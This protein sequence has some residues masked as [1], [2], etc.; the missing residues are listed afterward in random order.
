MFPPELGGEHEKLPR[1]TLAG[2]TLLHLCVE[3]EEMEI[4]TWL[5]DR[6][7]N[8][9]A[10]AAVDV[11]GFGG[12]TAL[13]GAVVS[14]SNTTGGSSPSIAMS[15]RWGGARCFRTSS[16]ECSRARHRA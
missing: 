4:A 5:R 15:P 10:P 1:T 16:S 12:H 6:G 9:D 8:V 2:A 7:M 13:F 11:E 3:F 14:Y